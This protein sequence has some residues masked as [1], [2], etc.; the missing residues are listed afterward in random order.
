MSMLGQASYVNFG[1]GAPPMQ[2]VSTWDTTQ[3]GTS[4]AN[5]IT[6]P[7][8]ASTTYPVQVDWG[9]GQTDTIT[10]ATDPNLTHTYAA[11]TTPTITMSGLVDGWAFNNGGDRRKLIDV[12]DW[13]GFVLNGTTGHFYGCSNANFSAPSRNII[14]SANSLNNSFRGCSSANELGTGAWDMSGVQDM[15]NAFNGWASIVVPFDTSGWITTAFTNLNSAFR[16]WV[17]CQSPLATDGWVL[18]NVGSFTNAWR[19]WLVCTSPM[20]TGGFGLGSATNLIAAWRGWR[21]C[22]TPMNTT[23]W[24]VSGVGLFNNVFFDWRA[25][26]GPMDTSLWVTT[27]ATSFLGAFQN[28]RACPTPP[29]VGGFDMNGVTS[30][31]DMFKDGAFTTP[32]DVG[33]WNTSTLQ[34]AGGAF[35]DLAS[36]NAFPDFSGWVTTALQSIL[37]MCQGISTPTTGPNISGWST[38]SLQNSGSSFRDCSFTTIAADALEVGALTDAT[39]M[40][41]GTPLSTASYDALLASW[42]AQTVQPNVGFHAGG[43]QYTGS[44][45]QANRDVLALTNGWTISDGGDNG[46]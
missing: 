18:N 20:Q 37:R 19:D 31:A 1:A 22:L 24:N 4:V 30:I 14:G 2:F 21:A 15:T 26:T 32:P 5:Q 16:G 7:L 41:N 42:A 17:L 9:D 27:A 12:T 35:M 8:T 34:N 46:L 25:L 3:P 43:A 6:L 28:W 39:D 13:G 38:P 45:Q 44:T 23:N 33:P 29:A 36:I 10:S 40:F 11:I